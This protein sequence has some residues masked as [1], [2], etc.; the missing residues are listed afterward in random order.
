MFMCKIVRRV[1]VI[2]KR[3]IQRQGK[4]T[5]FFNGSKELKI[6]TKWEWLYK[7]GGPA[8]FVPLAGQASPASSSHKGALLP[9]TMPSG[10]WIPSGSTILPVLTVLGSSGFLP[11]LMVTLP[12]RQVWVTAH[13]LSIVLSVYGK[14]G[15]LVD[16]LRLLGAI[17]L[18]VFKPAWSL[19]LRVCIT[20]HSGRPW[21]R[22]IKSN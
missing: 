22:S 12:A 14:M 3:V 8:E 5:G 20:L 15:W 2:D 19:F 11:I 9:M 13:N 4:D 7:A 17:S 6:L 21:A 10:N 1:M 18:T 16:Q